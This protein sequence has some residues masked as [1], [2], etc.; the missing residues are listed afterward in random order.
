MPIV[1]EAERIITITE[2]A[3]KQILKL[4]ESDPEQTAGKHLRVFVESGGCSGYSYGMEF[5]EADD[6]DFVM[7]F[8]GEKVLVDPKSSKFLQGLAVDFVTSWQETGFKITN[9]NATSVCGCGHSF[10]V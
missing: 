9:P 4:R 3:R 5:D 10:S 2:A 8:E 1:T 7:D 6:D